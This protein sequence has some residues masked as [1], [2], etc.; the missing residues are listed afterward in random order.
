MRVTRSNLIFASFIA[1]F[2]R[3]FVF[4]LD[5]YPDIFYVYRKLVDDELFFSIANRFDLF[6]LFES[7]SCGVITPDNPV[8]DYLVGGGSYKCQNFP[9]SFPYIYYFLIV[10]TVFLLIIFTFYK[11]SN[12]LQDSHKEFFRRI[13]LNSILLPS[14]LFFLLAL[15][16]DV[17]YHFLTFS[18]VFA[19]FLFAFQKRLRFLFPIFILPFFLILYLAPD[20]QS[21]IFA[22][23]YFAAALSLYLSKQNFILKI[24][25]K[26]SFQFSQI[27]DLK[28]FVYKKS[29]LKFLL[30]FLTVIF[31]ISFSGLSL[32]ELL[33]NSES[34]EKFGEINKIA[35]VY[36]QS[37]NA[38]EIAMLYKYP[39]YL[40]LLGVFQGIVILTP[41]GMKP[42]IITTVSFFSSFL[43]GFIRTFSLSSETSFIFFPNL[44]C[45]V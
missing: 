29:F 19:S 12:K 43:I 10:F 39:V 16:I 2:I 41:F 3:L 20:N 36:A 26:L 14:T 6:D 40:R 31:A 8:I 25:E 32:L 42:S 4:P 37:Q 33:G 21:I 15:H 22:I 11:L 18:F 38:D 7:Y 13:I 24:F 28:L 17:P 44:K 27:L 45:C 34:L 5:D 30:V 23:L 9:L 1:S 35:A